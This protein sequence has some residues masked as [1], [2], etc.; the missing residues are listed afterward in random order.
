MYILTSDFFEK[1]DKYVSTARNSCV[2]NLALK[3][4]FNVFSKQIR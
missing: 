2:R 4:V 3:Y 1:D